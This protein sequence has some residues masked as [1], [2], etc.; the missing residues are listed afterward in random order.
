MIGTDNGSLLRPW[1]LFSA[2]LGLHV[3]DEALTGFLEVYNPTVM[4]IRESWPWWP[5][6]TFASEGW[7]SGL[8]ALVVLLF[9]LTPV[10]L[11]AP[12]WFRLAASI[13]CVLMVLNAMGHII[14]SALGHTVRAVTFPRPA[15]GFWSS[16]VLLPASVW[17]L[18][19]LYRGGKKLHPAPA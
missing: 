17:L 15:P 7:L 2:A 18:C 13:F 3:L 8:I 14:F 12:A 10:A 4:A 9:L 1:L 16:L 6:P 11:R 5:M 19:R